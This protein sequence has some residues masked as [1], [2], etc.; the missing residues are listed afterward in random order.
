MAHEVIMPK[1]GFTQ[2]TAEIVRWLKHEGDVVE[3]GEPIAEVTTDKVNM[4]VEAPAS[5]ILA[6]VRYQEGEVVPVTQ[7]IAYILQPGEALPGGAPASAAAGTPPQEV[8]FPA[9]KPVEGEGVR[10][11]PV[12]ARLAEVAGV[13]PSQIQGSGPGGRVTRKDVEAYLASRQ[14]VEGKVRAVPA[15]RRLARELG[16]DL[17]Q[18]AGSG[19]QG[20]IQS[21]DVQRA[22]AT[23]AQTV[24]T[25]PEI[26][27]EVARPVAPAPSGETFGVQT[28]IAQ[29]IPLAGMRKVIAQRMQQSAQNAPHI[30]LEITVD[31]TAAE[32]LR[33]RANQR[34]KEGQTKV[35][36]TAVIARACAWALTQHP[37]LNAW[38]ANTPQGEQILIPAQVN[39]GIAVAVEEGLIV[40]VVRDAARKNLLQLAG[41][42]GDLVERARGNRLR[43]EDVVEGTFTISNL[44]M[45]GIERFTA[46]I[47]PPQVAILAVGSLRR[48]VV[49]DAE[50]K[51]QVRPVFSLTLCADHRVVDGAVAARFL[52]DLREAL[53]QPEVMVV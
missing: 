38:L 45:L 47:N 28:P 46:I 32:A 41:E 39:L 5:G 22:Y 31:A 25:V 13:D 1:F 44:G 40:P 17:N 11:T 18:V 7:V 20:R 37:R 53:E 12:A 51:I 14:E 9:E 15:A 33:A 29:V 48:E 42:I 16:V 36:L 26:A 35:S 19:P 23:R 34:L 43:P 3:Q 10:V 49:A 24:A 50:G 4:E 21:E 27:P 6:G 30:H 52:A 2:E 8:A